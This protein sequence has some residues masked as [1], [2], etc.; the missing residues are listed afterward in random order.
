M[1]EMSEDENERKKGIKKGKMK[2]KNVKMFIS[3]I[4]LQCSIPNIS[5]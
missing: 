1:K 2:E 3:S 5:L 4:Q